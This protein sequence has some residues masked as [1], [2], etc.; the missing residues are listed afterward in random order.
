LLF[1]LDHLP[2]TLHLVLAT[3]IDPDL[4]LSRLRIRGQMIEIG[5]SDLRFAREEASSFLLQSMNLPL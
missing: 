5:T 3:R 1:L 4:F 2:D